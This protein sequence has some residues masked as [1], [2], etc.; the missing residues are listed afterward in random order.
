MTTTPPIG[1]WHISHYL[2]SAAGSAP[3]PPQAVPTRRV[4]DRN[5]VTPPA[6]LLLAGQVPGRVDFAAPSPTGPGLPFYRHP[7][8][9]NAAATAVT[10]GRT[11]D[12]EA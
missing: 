10:A 12:L 6:R 11:L 1:A 8:D 5:E 9:R 2:K 4:P 3:A 7:A